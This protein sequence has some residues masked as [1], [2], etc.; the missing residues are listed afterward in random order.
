MLGASGVTVSPDGKYVY[1]I[2]ASDDAVAVFSRDSAT[3][4]LTFV[5]VQKDG[6]GTLNDPKA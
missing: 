4:K 5:E 1:A 3:G 2:G 6:V